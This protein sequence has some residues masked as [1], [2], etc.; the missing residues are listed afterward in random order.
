M[1]R[2]EACGLLLAVLAISCLTRADAF[3]VPREMSRCRSA[4]V[5]ELRVGGGTLADEWAAR[6][7][8]SEAALACE[9][10]L[11]DASRTVFVYESPNGSVLDEFVL[12]AGE[13]LQ[14]SLVNCEAGWCR[15]RLAD[16]RNAWVVD[17]F[18]D[19]FVRLK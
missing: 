8:I 12:D 1:R 18:P 9:M 5:E 7:E 6:E 14:I 16:G 19:M 4:P 11:P 15:I 2:L 3:L 10:S 13:S 17:G